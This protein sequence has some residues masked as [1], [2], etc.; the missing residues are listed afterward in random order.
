MKEIKELVFEEMSLEQKLSFVNTCFIG[1]SSTPEQEEY[2]YDLVKKRAV[3]AIWVQQKG[4]IDHTLRHINRIRELADYPVLIM[5]DSENCGFNVDYNE[6]NIGNHNAVSRTGDEKAA[7]AFGKAVGVVAR[8]IG[9]NVVCNPLLDTHTNGSNRSFG[10]DKEIVAKFGAA[11]ARGMHDAGILTVAKHYPSGRNDLGVDTH[12][13][14]GF[15]LETEQDL[16]NRGLYPYIEL[17]KEDLLDGI[18]TGHHKFVNIDSERPASLSKPVL[19]ILR[20]QGFDGFY[21][22]DA[23]TMMGIQAKFGKKAPPAMCIEAGNDLSLPFFLTNEEINKDFAKCFEEGIVSEEAVNTAVKRILAAQHK[24]FLY[25]TNRAIEL[26]A[27]EADLARNIDNNGVFAKTDDGFKAAISR[28]GKY[29]FAVMSSN[30]YPTAGVS[31]DVDTFGDGWHDPKKICDKIKELFP[32]AEIQ[33]FHQFPNQSQ[34]YRILNNSFGF[35]EVIFVTYSQPWAY[36]GAEH[37]T[38]RVVTL[39]EAMQYTNRISTLVHLG[40]PKLVGELPHFNRI[41]LGGASKKAAN[42]SLEVLAGQRDA[43]GML[44]YTVNFK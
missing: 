21:I 15:S 44:T 42:A 6:Y 34:M 31:V 14:E 13:V 41:I 2:V 22:T 18:M 37:F 23:L 39:L 9:Y 8:K 29:Y 17:I 24:V 38:H 30:V 11:E 1:L 12:M 5:T 19:D 28:D 16:L 26:A 4:D 20:R 3:G 40:N 7:Y 32:N 33:I 43:K 36:T 27:E 25:D 35:D 10:E